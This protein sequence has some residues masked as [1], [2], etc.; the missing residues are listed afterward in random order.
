MYPQWDGGGGEQ[1]GGQPKHGLTF[2]SVAQLP[3]LA[4][5][6]ETLGQRIYIAETAYPA[7]GPSQP[8]LNFTATPKGQLQYLQALRAAVA[9]ALGPKRNGGVLWWEGS[10]CGGWNS[11]FDD[12]CVARPVAL[13]AFEQ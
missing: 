12:D 10:E 1:H 2:Q 11:L 4:E 3:K 9:N 5:A 6:F 13:K 8:E 7:A